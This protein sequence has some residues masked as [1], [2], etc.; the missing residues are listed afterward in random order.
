[1]YEHTCPFSL[2]FEI[3]T[4]SCDE[5]QPKRKIEI[6]IQSANTLITVSI[7]FNFYK[8]KK[9]I[10]FQY[11]KINHKFKV[12]E[13]FRKYRSNCTNYGKTDN[14]SHFLD[15]YKIENWNMKQFSARNKS[16]NSTL[17]CRIETKVEQSQ[18][19][20]FCE[21]AKKK[22]AFVARR[23]K[24]AMIHSRSGIFFEFQLKYIYSDSAIKYTKTKRITH[25]IH[26]GLKKVEI[27]SRG[28]RVRST[29]TLIIE[30]SKQKQN[31]K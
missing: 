21:I 12:N 19:R 6:C 26:L 22:R 2:V 15:R 17:L 23:V 25:R 28:L 20:F 24:F 3:M 29:C 11:F 7:I 13:S 30:H 1:M 8:K 10:T 5:S 16:N 31:W 4:S 9:L 14:W 18:I 27:N